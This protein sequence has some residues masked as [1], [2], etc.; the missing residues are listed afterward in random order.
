MYPEIELW[1]TY[2]PYYD[3]RNIHLY[4]NVL[5]FHAVEFTNN[6]IKEKNKKEDEKKGGDEFFKFE[7]RTKKNKKE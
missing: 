6:Y 3:K 7:K 5:G 1:I 4:M 2:T